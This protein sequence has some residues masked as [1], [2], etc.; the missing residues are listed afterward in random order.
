MGESV[1]EITIVFNHFQNSNA[2]KKLI[3]LFIV[4][5]SGMTA[6]AQ[7]DPKP[8]MHSMTKEHA[9]K[10]YYQMKDGKVWNMLNERPAPL[11]QEVTLSNG[12]TL[13]PEGTVIEKNGQV[14]TLNE[15]DKVYMDGR[16]E[17]AS[18]QK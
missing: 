16:V 13:K 9:M 14:T 2:M 15:G 10:N 4:M 7:T 6:I 17:K 3:V 11:E 12:S 18:S 1:V 8:T 5:A